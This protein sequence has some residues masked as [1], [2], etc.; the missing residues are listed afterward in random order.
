MKNQEVC[1]SHYKAALVISVAL[2]PFFFFFL[3]S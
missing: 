1:S 2:T 3:Q